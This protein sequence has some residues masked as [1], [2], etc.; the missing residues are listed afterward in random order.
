MSGIF[1]KGVILEWDLLRVKD[2]SPQ[3]E[4]LC[5]DHGY[6]LDAVVVQVGRQCQPK[7][8]CEKSV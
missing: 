6:K 7:G 2:D 8:I 1:G 5:F 4:M 3:R